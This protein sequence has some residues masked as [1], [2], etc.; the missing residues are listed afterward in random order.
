MKTLLMVALVLVGG[1][2][3]FNYWNGAPLL[4]NPRDARP[5][6]VGT[7]GTVDVNAARERGADVGER[8]A[9]A[10]GKL[11]DNA[12][13]AA[14]TSKIKAKMMLDDTI[15]ARSIDVT[16]EGTTV[17]VSGAVRS[18]EEHDR[19]IRLARETEGVTH[20]VDRLKVESK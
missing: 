13:E 17:T 14:L 10:A 11:R 15:K 7:G 18:V 3:A 2:V 1:V 12:H 4:S 9:V 19:A 20:V 8:V 5:A 6:A 16:T